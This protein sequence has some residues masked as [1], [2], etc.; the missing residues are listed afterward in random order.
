MA[1]Y[2]GTD[3]TPLLGKP[4]TPEA[5]R[6]YHAIDI[7]ESIW[8]RMEELGINQTQLAEKLGKNCSQVSRILSAQTNMTLQTLSELEHALGITL[9][10]TTPYEA[11]VV[12]ESLPV[13][14]KY[15]SMSA[16]QRTKFKIVEAHGTGTVK[17][18]G[19]AA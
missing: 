10:D 1:I 15:A 12:H 16:W 4:H 13:S 11:H 17:S 19:V 3:L 6:H 18:R 5:R 14:P 7:S 9:A 2:E 8:N